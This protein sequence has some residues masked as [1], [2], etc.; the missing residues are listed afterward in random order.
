MFWE[1]CDLSVFLIGRCH[2]SM[3]T[4][5]DVLNRESVKSVSLWRATRLEWGAVQEALMPR[6]GGSTPGEVPPRR[7]TPPGSP[8][9]TDLYHGGPHQEF[10]WVGLIKPSCWW[11]KGE[12]LHFLM[13]WEQ[14]H[15]SH[16]LWCRQG[17]EPIGNNIEARKTL[18]GN[19]WN[20]PKFHGGRIWTHPF[21][22]PHLLRGMNVLRK[23]WR[24]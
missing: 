1:T 9:T 8:A 18:M 2:F 17:Q 16:E 22:A 12:N 11:L 15:V 3:A 10:F 23:W 20:Q 5:L 6:P 24:K 13:A 19:H 14:N 7:E 4:Y 21:R